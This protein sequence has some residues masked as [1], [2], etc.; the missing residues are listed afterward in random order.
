VKIHYFWRFGDFRPEVRLDEGRGLATEVLRVAGLGLTPRVPSD[1]VIQNVTDQFQISAG[2]GLPQFGLTATGNINGGVTISWNISAVETIS[3]ADNDLQTYFSSVLPKLRK[4]ADS[5]PKNNGWIKERYVIKQVVFA[6]TV[7]ER[8]TPLKQL[9]AKRRLR[10][11][12]ARAV[13]IFR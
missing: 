5:D 4:F 7:P 13:P 12:E 3:F 9:M 6:A 8:F 1:I 10:R 11:R 2:V